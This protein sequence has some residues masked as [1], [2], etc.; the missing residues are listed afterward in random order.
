MLN[1][2]MYFS[3]CILWS[4]I[5]HVGSAMQYTFKGIVGAI[6]NHSVNKTAKEL[7][8]LKKP[9]TVTLGAS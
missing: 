9:E 1:C 4:L 2:I 3:S 7:S 8:W 5:I 6:Y